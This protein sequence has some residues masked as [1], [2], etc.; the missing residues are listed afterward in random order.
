MSRRSNIFHIELDSHDLIIAEGSLSESFI[1]D[2]SRA[3][4]HNAHDYDTLYADEVRRPA[5]YCAPRLDEGYQLEAVRRRL[6]QRAGLLCSADTPRTGAVRGYIDRVRTSRIFGWAQN[7][8]APE[9]AV[10]LDIYAEGKFI[11]RVL[12]N[13]YRDDLKAAGL[14]SGRHGFEFAAPAGVEF[15]ADAIEVR[16]ALDGAPLGRSG[17]ARFAP[18]EFTMH[19]GAARM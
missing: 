6:T 15:A 17:P 3:M 5:S 2:D 10:C 13:A 12:A 1:D 16:R 14:G 11:G 18:L 7:I 19:R 9:A 8:D 4:F